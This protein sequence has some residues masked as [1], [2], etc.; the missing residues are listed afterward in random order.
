[1]DYHLDHAVWLKTDTE[2]KSLY[3]WAICE[4]DGERVQRDQIPWPWTL[5][6]SATK[7]SLT[8]QIEIE[9]DPSPSYVPPRQVIGISLR[10]T[11][12][13]GGK[14]TRGASY[15]MFGTTRRIE[16][17]SLQ[18]TPLTSPDEKENCRAWGCV[19]YTSE[20]DFR[21]ET[22]ED[23]LCFYLQVNA[24]TF[25]RYVQIMD[26]GHFSSAIFSVGGVDGF[27][28][29]WSP[30]IST[31][32]VKVLASGNEQRLELPPS[33]KGEVP[34]LGHVSSAKLQFHRQITMPPPLED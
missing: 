33:I 20:I 27:Y 11:A 28:S 16:N 24:G 4:D 2:H 3:T 10:P 22:T 1:M 5:H 12:W 21:K 18:V 31:H 8:D 15:S 13:R 9:K 34:R 19:S 14:Y 6:F 17:F 32:A 23:C 29:D 25:E 7:C 30:S 26:R